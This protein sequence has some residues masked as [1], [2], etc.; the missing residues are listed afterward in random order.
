MNAEAEKVE[1]IGNLSTKKINKIIT[2]TSQ[3]TVTMMITELKKERFFKENRHS[4]YQKTE[5]LLYNYNNFKAAIKD[6]EDQIADIQQWGLGQRSKDIVMIPTGGTSETTPEEDKIV[7]LQH[8]IQITKKFIELVDAALQRIRKDK[9]FDVIPMLY[10]EGKSREYIAERFEVDVSTIT[11]N[12]NRL[13]NRLKISLFSDEVI[14]EI[15]S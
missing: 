5:H 12:K 10:F 11:R 7:A 14:M 9:Y 8:S 1:N 6:K 13:I 2:K 3:E 4:P 15:F